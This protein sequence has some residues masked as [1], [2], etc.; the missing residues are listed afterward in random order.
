[1]SLYPADGIFVCPICRAPL[2]R[3][4]GSLVCPNRHAYDIAKSGY[5][6]LLRESAGRHGDGKE[7]V[8]ARSAFLEKGYYAPLQKALTEL[9]E[10]MLRQMP[11]GPDD[12][13]A[14]RPS[15][16]RPA[17]LLDS[18]CGEGYYTGALAENSALRVYGVD[19]SARAAAR[20]AR[21]KG[22]C[23]VAVASAYDLPVATES[24]DVV[25]NLFSPFCR[26]EFYR[27]LKKKGRLIN[28]VPGPRHLFELKEILYDSPYEKPPADS[29][30]EGFSLLTGRNLSY[31]VTLPCRED[32]ASLLQVTPYY[33]RTDKKGH[34]R[35]EALK[36]LTVRAEFTL[37]AY[38]KESEPSSSPR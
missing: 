38:Q 18:G 10:Q 2:G 21:R 28:V 31:T 36:T 34:A 7:M 15:G 29:A 27:V 8:A 16:N 6:N 11:D 24:C 19:I 26:E 17:I 22:V 5:V 3:S 32:I 12:Q 13:T 23:S 1:M 4:D 35:A 37:L 9:V 20:A 30:V 33:Y 14:G 25:T